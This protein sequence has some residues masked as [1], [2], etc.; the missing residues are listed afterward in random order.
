MSE[1]LAN[2]GHRHGRDHRLRVWRIE[3]E[4]FGR[5]DVKLPM[6]GADARQ[7]RQPWLLH[8]MAVNALNFCTFALCPENP[9]G[10]ELCTSKQEELDAK[11]VIESDGAGDGIC[12]P[13]K[14]HS[15]E[16]YQPILIASPNGLD[17]GGIDI[18]H[19]PS[20]HRVCKLPSDTD[21]KTGMVMALG[22]LHHPITNNLLLVSGYEDGSTMVHACDKVER[23]ESVWKWRKMLLSRPHTQP[24]LSLDIHPSAE[25]YFTSSADAIIA[26]FDVPTPKSS[27]EVTSQANKIVNTKHAGQQGLVMR[28]DGKIFATAGWDCRVRVY[29]AKTLKEVAVLRWHKEACYAV[30]FAVIEP[31]LKSGK[32]SDETKSQYPNDST[33]LTL[34]KRIPKSALDIIRAERG[35]A[36]QR[37]HWIAAGGKDGKISLW[38]IY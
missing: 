11:P 30:A 22:L 28:S 13:E 25:F 4:G 27:I 10:P 15:G 31:S 17:Q 21:I 6:E 18:F 37:T 34:A 8:S 24:I 14:W 16:D 38:D 2:N 7:N 35:V 20:E 26:K 33:E 3:I 29:S 1:F 36:A 12:S 5:L 19:L 9:A 32:D 23:P